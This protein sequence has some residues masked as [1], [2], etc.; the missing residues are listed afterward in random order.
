M[1]ERFLLPEDAGVPAPLT[2]TEPTDRTFEIAVFEAVKRDVRNLGGPARDLRLTPRSADRG[3]DI[4]VEGFEGSGLLGVRLPT[5]PGS[6]SIYVECKLSSRRRLTLE[7]VAANVLQL[8]PETGSIFLLVTNSTLTPRA[9]SKIK[10]Q[11]D[12]LGL[13]FMLIDAWSM[14]F[15]LPQLIAGSASIAPEPHALISYQVL[16]DGP[17]A[18]EYTIHFVFRAV[19]GIGA[20]FEIALHSTRD[21][22]G[23]GM[24]RSSI[25]LHDGQLTCWCLQVAPAGLKPPPFLTVALTLNGRNRLIQISLAAGDDI[26]HLPL[27]PSEMARLAVELKAKLAAHE[28]PMLTLVHGKGG[29]GKSRLVRELF[30]LAGMQG[31][32]CRLITLLDSGGALVASHGLNEAGQ[33]R[34]P[35]T[36]VTSFFRDRLTPGTPPGEEVVLLDDVHL[37]SAALLEDLSALAFGA[38]ARAS[39]VVGGRSDP[40]FRR[41]AYEAFETRVREHG[42]AAEIEHHLLGEM[43]DL[44]VQASL[45]ALFE[46]KA[47]GLISMHGRKTRL[48]PI[49]LVHAIHSLIERNHVFWSDEEKLSLSPA[50]SGTDYFSA[51]ETFSGILEYRYQHLRSAECNG[52]ALAGFLEV[53][54]IVDEPRA[55]YVAA[56]KLLEQTDVMR[57]IIALWLEVDDLSRLATFRHVI[58]RD[59]L[60]GKFYSFKSAPRCSAI[61]DFVTLADVQPNDEVLAAFALSNG[62]AA[63]AASLIV[64]FARS[65]ARVRNISS[66]DLNERAYNKLATLFAIL[67]EARMMRP[68]LIYRCIAARAYLNAHHR[69]YS[70]GFIDNLWLISVVDALPEFSGKGLTV[71]VV[72]QLMAHALINSGDSRTAVSLMHE[73]ANYLEAQPPTRAGMTIEFDMCDRLQAHY[74]HQSAFKPARM[75]F[76]RARQC[77]HSV[78]DPAVLSVSFSAEF[79][80]VRYLDVGH[81]LE[82]AERQ[83]K[84]AERAAPKRALIHA[85]VNEIVARWVVRGGPLG[86]AQLTMLTA[87]RDESRSSGFGHL[88]SR[89]DCLIVINAFQDWKRGEGSLQAL[90]HLLAEGN[91][92]ARGYGYEEYIW[93]IASIELLTLIG[94]HADK[95]SIVRK[96][97]WLVDHL[98]GL[99]LT[100]VAGDELC[101]PNTIVLS[102]ALRALHE[103][104]D[105]ATAWS[106]ANKI[107][108]SPLF[109]PK[110]SDRTERLGSVFEGKM[111]NHIYDPKAVLTG[112]GY[113]IVHV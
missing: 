66:L 103:F 54:A 36:K 18:D 105:Q 77:A 16:K 40:S 35:D 94:R 25:E 84:H 61:L 83:L 74:T 86:R 19:G 27:F 50:G 96:A 26:A 91:D 78:A 22:R 69:A 58:L 59:F 71:A 13:G 45:S 72:K 6:R 3:R 100:F 7:H 75:F 34:W 60:A 76:L 68:V 102:N 20:Q 87:L 15:C 63:R 42:P 97:A 95:L 111:L 47:A 33:V 2:L 17:R 4:V 90:E 1:K 38:G 57:D 92:S 52:F 29:T 44:E 98:H 82:L 79:H 51:D 14:P 85:K 81:A 112:D 107:S 88:I 62:D 11:C 110:P 80:L 46:E 43:T 104:S 32:T 101:F 31:A 106:F 28:L 37:A 113:A 89:L 5:G 64:P 108:F 39:M 73:V 48:R 12:R 24:D 93:M 10:D 70:L 65:L 67:R 9:L 109:L 30:D 41:P 56:V 99:G 55:S 49:D 21:W 23:T 53:L 8:E